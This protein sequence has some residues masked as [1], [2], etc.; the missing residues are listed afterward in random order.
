MHCWVVV[1]P[2]WDPKD[3]FSELY[4]QVL[5]HPNYGAEMGWP[6]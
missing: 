5:V 3:R 6:S 1:V 2:A 4:D